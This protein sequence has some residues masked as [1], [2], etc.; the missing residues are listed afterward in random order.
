[1]HIVIVGE[2]AART[3]ELDR[4]LAD[5][6]MEARWL[7]DPAEAL[8]LPAEKPIHAFVLGMRAAGL[9]GPTLLAQLG[10]LHPEAVRILLLDP[11]QK[12]PTWIDA[13]IDS[14]GDTMLQKTVDTSDDTSA[15]V[16]T[17]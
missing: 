3:S 9:H 2:Q 14:S 12:H 7:A 1:M 17:L 5:F 16:V 6:D 4:A 11:I 10:A 8:A 13:R 15:G